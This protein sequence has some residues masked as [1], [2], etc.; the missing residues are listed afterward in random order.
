[1]YMDAFKYILILCCINNNNNNNNNIYIYVC[2]I[3]QC[4]QCH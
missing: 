4:V 3:T 1:M 2:M